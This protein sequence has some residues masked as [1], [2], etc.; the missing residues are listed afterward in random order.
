MYLHLENCSPEQARRGGAERLAQPWLGVGLG[1]G[2]KAP[3]RKGRLGVPGSCRLTEVGS[4]LCE[5][6]AACNGVVT[7][8]Q[9]VM[10]WLRKVRDKLPS[11]L[12][13]VTADT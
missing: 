5:V 11:Q 13:Q 3:K 6:A 2:G 7:S 4:Y 12:P 1:Q 8:L 10:V 9:H